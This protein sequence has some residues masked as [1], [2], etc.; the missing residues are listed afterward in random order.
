M[1]K[2][3]GVPV[4]TDYEIWKNNPEKVFGVTAEWAE[5]NPNTTLAVIKA[6]IR[7]GKWLDASNDAN[8]MEAVKILVQARIRRRRRTRSS[9][10]A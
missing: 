10:T 3:I 1:F 8:R 9:P 2:G 5:K 4:V 6:L 7:A